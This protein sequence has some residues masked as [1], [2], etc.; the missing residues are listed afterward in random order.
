MEM[1]KHEHP[2][3]TTPDELKTAFAEWQEINRQMQ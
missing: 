2:A 1:T 3:V